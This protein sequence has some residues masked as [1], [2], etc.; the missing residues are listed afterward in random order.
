MYEFFYK[1]DGYIKHSTPSIKQITVV[2]PNGDML[3][4]AIG[5]V[6][7]WLNNYEV[8]TITYDKTHIYIF[9]EDDRNIPAI[10]FPLSMCVINYKKQGVG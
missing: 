9:T 1:S 3:D 6:T 5:H 4:F 8:T 2:Y 7:G 10:A